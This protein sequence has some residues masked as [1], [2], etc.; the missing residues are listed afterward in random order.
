M[1]CYVNY[2][3][4]NIKKIWKYSYISMDSPPACKKVHRNSIEGE[5]ELAQ[6]K[7]GRNFSKTTLEIK[8]A[9][10]GITGRC[11]IEYQII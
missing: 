9:T 7:A 3:W 4:C 6:Y 10:D 8:P 11:L 5:E 1:H 2:T